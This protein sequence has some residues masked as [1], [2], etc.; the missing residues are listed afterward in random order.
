MVEIP[1]R[2][3]RRCEQV[4]VRTP[5]VA[6][7]T[8][9]YRCRCRVWNA[10]IALARRFPASLDSA[11]CPSYYSHV[12]H[13]R[14]AGLLKYASEFL[15]GFSAAVLLTQRPAADFWIRNFGDAVVRKG[16]AAPREVQS[17]ERWRERTQESVPWVTWRQAWCTMFP[18]ST[19]AQLADLK[20]VLGAHA[21]NVRRGWRRLLT[22]VVVVLV[23]RRSVRRRTCRALTSR[24]CSSGVFPLCGARA[25][26]VVVAHC[27]RMCVDT[28]H[29]RRLWSSCRPCSRRYGFDAGRRSMP[30]RRFLPTNPRA[31]SCC[32]F[33]P[34]MC[35]HLVRRRC[36]VAVLETALMCAC[37]CMCVFFF[38]ILQRFIWSAPVVVW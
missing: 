17:S 15:L 38:D 8:L 18:Q 31:P 32:A 33:P 14:L 37:V 2:K 9:W 27:S 36:L 28:E 5:K 13:R 11:A 4:A 1:D 29:C 23:Q 26:Y 6:D 25:W 21:S 34:P 16:A 7:N 22:V 10:F 20:L 35:M 19:E 24:C 3:R 12:M 30:L